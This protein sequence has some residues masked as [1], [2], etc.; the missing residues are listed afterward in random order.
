MK[1]FIII[2]ALAILHRAWHALPKL[3]NKEGKIINAVYG[4]SSFLL[5]TLKEEKPDYL[6]VA[7]DTEIPSFRKKEFKEY[8]ANRVPQPQEFYNQIPLS[9]KILEAFSINFFSLEGQEADD[10]ISSM[11]AHCQELT[12]PDEIIIFTGDKDILQLINKKTKVALLKQ[13]ISQ[14]KIY[15]KNKVEKEYSGLSPEQLIDFKALVGDP[16]DNIPGVKGIGPRF[17]TFLLKKYRSLENLY[18][19]IEKNK[20]KKE[21]IKERILN[22][23]IKEKEQVFLFKRLVKLRSDLNLKNFKLENCH[24][25]KIDKEKIKKLFNEIGFKGLIGRLEALN[26]Q[27]KSLF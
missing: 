21:K 4:F 6:A 10:L 15:D 25:Q 23:L 3:T 5:K 16:A 18:E 17:A 9:K 22:A 1:K 20:I 12:K 2:D 13:N 7:Y 26:S 14:T 11:T 24:L 19:L 27:Q 8:K